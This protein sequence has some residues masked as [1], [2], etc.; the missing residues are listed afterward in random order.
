M[1]M[2]KKDFI[3]LGTWLRDTHAMYEDC[4]LRQEKLAE[5]LANLLARSNPRFNREV[6]LAYV[7][8]ECGPSGGKPK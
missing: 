6:W 3:A 8:R 5:E 2:S 1:S 4:D 7:N